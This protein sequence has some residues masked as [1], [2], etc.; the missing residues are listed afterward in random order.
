MLTL[1]NIRNLAIAE[2]VSVELGPG[3][4]VITGETGAGKSILAG[5]LGLVLGARADKS[6]VRSGE[7]RSTV[8]ASFELA[9][10]KAIDLLL[11]EVGVTP[12]EDGVLVVRRLISTTSAARNLINDCPVTL[13]IL[14]K[15]GD[16]L[17]DQHGPHDH[18]SLL[19]QDNQ[20][21][22]LD[23]Y[24]HT[25][26][27]QASYTQAYQAR[28]KLDQERAELE[29]DAGVVAQEIDRLTFQIEEIKTADLEGVDEETLRQ[30]HDVAGN[31]GQIVELATELQTALIGDDRSAF[32]TLSSSQ[33]AMQQLAEL[34][35]EAKEW[36]SELTTLSMQ[37]QELGT[38]ISSTAQG[39][40]CDP[41]RMQWLDDKLTALLRLKRKYGSTIPAILK[42]LADTEVRL[43]QLESREERLAEIDAAIA[44]ADA[45]LREA[46]MAL[47]KKRKAGASKL[48]KAI[49]KQLRGLGFEHSDFDIMLEESE[50]PR[51]SG[52]DV[53]DFGFAPNVGEEKRPL[54]AI[55]S[56]GEI[57]RVMLAVKS[58]LADHDRIPVLV[59]DEIDAN[60]GGE[61]GNAIGERMATIAASRQ[62]VCITH[63]PQVAVH[64]STHLVVAKQVSEGRTRTAIQTVCDEDR[65]GEIARMLGGKDLTSVAVRHAREMLGMGTGET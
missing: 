29:G 25:S 59:F 34:Y 42:Y 53:A 7:T 17:V 51:P 45:T 35:P 30:E 9:D 14:R 6:M 4:N 61:I 44:A 50:K 18:Q 62:V 26:S 58:V 52:L 57:S 19:V 22:I 28:L 16:L 55:A 8:V 37:V 24:A 48:G 15:L 2:D 27:Q 65:V 21:A 20:L 46:G 23:S 31:A 32:T 10:S 1:L 43:E 38:T 54:R 64:G 12:C 60:V 39:I 36:Q 5:A 11:D 63:L 3:L 13:Q 40:E 56:S 49:H 33:R 41:E 47:R